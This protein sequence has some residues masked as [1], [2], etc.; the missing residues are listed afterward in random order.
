MNGLPIVDVNIGNEQYKFVL[1]T[2]ASYCVFHTSFL[3]SFDVKPDDKGLFNAPTITC[4]GAKV[5]DAVSQIADLSVIKE[6][7]GASGIIGY[8]L[9]KDYVSH[10]DLH[11]GRFVYIFNSIIGNKCFNCLMGN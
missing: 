3:N 9:L 4:G 10:F 1:D 6:S 5:I 11:R 2:G 8:Q 7:F